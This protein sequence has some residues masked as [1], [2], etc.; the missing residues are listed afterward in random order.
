MGTSMNKVVF[1]ENVIRGIKIWQ[2]RAKKNMA[3]RN[4][5]SQATLDD[6]S[7]SHETAL[8]NSPSF[9]LYA[10]VF[11]PLN[12]NKH[13]AVNTTE[14]EKVSEQLLSENQETNFG[15]FQGFELQNTGKQ[16]QF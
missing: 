5:H 16:E 4:P 6:T 3:L 10:S 14:G 7:V 1:T 15:S 8:E 11:I 12:V 2:D 9:N 13:M